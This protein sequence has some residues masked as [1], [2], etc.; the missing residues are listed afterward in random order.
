[1]TA[2]V[3]AMTTALNIHVSQNLKNQ[4]EIYSRKLNFYIANLVQMA[5]YIEELMQNRD[6]MNFIKDI[7]LPISEK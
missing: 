3:V 4:L 5:R 6:L 1:M 2:E 7:I